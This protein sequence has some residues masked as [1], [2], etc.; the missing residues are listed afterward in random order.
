MTKRAVGI[1]LSFVILTMPLSGCKTEKKRYQAQ[2]LNLFDTVTEIIAYT[3]NKEE[4]EIYAKMIHDELKTYHQLYDIYEDY[5]GIVNLKTV[6]EN[7]GKE[8]VKVDKKIIDLLKFA[9]YAYDLTGG[10]TNVALGAVLK[11]WHSYRQ[12]GTDNPQN[13][14]LPP[15]EMLENANLHSNIDDVVIDEINSTV[16]FKDKD[17]KLDV[18]AVA[19]G[20]AVEQVAKFASDMGVSSM[21]IS[22]GGNICAIGNKDEDTPWNVGILNPNKEDEQKNLYVVNIKDMAMVTSGDYQRTYTVGGK[23]YHHIINPQ[24]L[25]P[26]EYFTAVTVIC[27]DSG[28]ADALS[29]ALFNMPFEEGFV[30]VEAIPKVEAVWLFKDKTTKYTFGFEGFIKE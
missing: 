24:T 13:A 6:N 14:K 4:F 27:E 16:F 3:N 25:Y 10:K 5:E 26:A 17:L 12:D 18:G 22:V 29:T 19:K 20:Y 2:F 15:L 30:F 1:F 11:I 23:Q 21:L 28:L 7:A 9:K 8:P